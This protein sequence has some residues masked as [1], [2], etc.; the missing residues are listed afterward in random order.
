MMEI[1]QICW[2]NIDAS[3]PEG[4][5]QRRN[6]NNMQIYPQVYRLKSGCKLLHNTIVNTNC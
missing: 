3:F 4:F 6:N 1:K 2:V 5:N